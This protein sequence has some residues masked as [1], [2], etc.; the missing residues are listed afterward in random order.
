MSKPYN[1]WGNAEDQNDLLRDPWAEENIHS[2]LT[3]APQTYPTS[4]DKLGFT[5]SKQYTI[6]YVENNLATNINLDNNQNE[7]SPKSVIYQ[8]DSIDGFQ[9]HSSNNSIE[10]ESGKDVDPLGALLVPSDMD[11]NN[12]TSDTK[13]KSEKET[14]D[15]QKNVLEVSLLEPLKVGGDLLLSGHVEYRL[16]TVTSLPLFRNKECSVMR[17]YSDFLWLYSLLICGIW[18]PGYIVPGVPSKQAVGRFETEFIEFRRRALER[19]IKKVVEFKVWRDLECTRFFL[20][21]E[22]FQNDVSCFWN[23][24]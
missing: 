17:R 6:Q 8:T 19:W 15:Q 24:N 2:T 13:Q 10:L 21:S 18:E 1:P 5:T 9:R 14:S 20:E 11:T 4:N 3:E 7:A 22:T 23:M 16:K 12:S